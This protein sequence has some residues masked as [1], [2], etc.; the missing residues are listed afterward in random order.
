MPPG[1]AHVIAGGKQLHPETALAVRGLEHARA[2]EFPAGPLGLARGADFK[3]ARLAQVR[4]GCGLAKPGFFAEHA[5]GAETRSGKAKPVRESR[6]RDHPVLH[7]GEDDSGLAEPWQRVQGSVNVV[8]VLDGRGC[9]AGKAGENPAP[10][11]DVPDLGDIRLL[12][13][14][15]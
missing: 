9:Q 12:D 2:A 13:N 11:G 5:R 4:P 6:R 3:P 1:P 7:A 10:S 15:K 14:G 8:F